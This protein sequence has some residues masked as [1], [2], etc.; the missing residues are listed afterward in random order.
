MPMHPSSVL[1]PN[2]LNLDP[3]PEGYVNNFELKNV[4]NIFLI[5]TGT[6]NMAPG[7]IISQ[8]L[9]IVNFSLQSYTFCL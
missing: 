7:E 1:D 3:D 6:G 4:K 5:C 2:T 9:L 8:C